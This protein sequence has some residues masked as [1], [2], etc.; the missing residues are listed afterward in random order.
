M[1]SSPEGQASAKVSVL[2]R[3]KTCNARAH[4]L[5]LANSSPS[6]VRALVRAWVRAWVRA[7]VCS[8]VMEE[9]E[10]PTSPLHGAGSWKYD[11][12]LKSAL[13]QLQCFT[14]SGP[15]R[16]AS[17]RGWNGEET[18]VWNIV[19]TR[20]ALEVRYWPQRA[21]AAWGGEKL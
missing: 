11:V 9:A 17:A 2:G 3:S 19:E 18:G 12:M 21:F 8:V 10:I 13:Q 16:G 20:S 4:E 6:P 7:V 1:D 14:F 5:A 15:K